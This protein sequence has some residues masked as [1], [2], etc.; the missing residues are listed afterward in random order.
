M[1]RRRQQSGRGKHSGR[2]AHWASVTN[3]HKI[4]SRTV[5]LSCLGR[6]RLSAR[7]GK[8]DRCRLAT[9]HCSSAS[10]TLQPPLAWTSRNRL[11]TK[12]GVPGIADALS[13][14]NQQGNYLPLT[15]P[16]TARRLRA[17]QIR[18]LRFLT[19]PAMSCPALLRGFGTFACDRSAHLRIHAST[20]ATLADVAVELF[21]P[22]R[23]RHHADAKV[24]GDACVVLAALLAFPCLSCQRLAF[25][26]ATTLAWRIH[27]Q[28]P[29][30]LERA[31][32]DREDGFCSMLRP[33]PQRL[34][35]LRLCR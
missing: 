14:P 27:L 22:R 35:A 30:C 24:L 29:A 6:H 18:R 28:L 4:P 8:G 19:R 20:K 7:R 33:F 12:L 21:E 34:A 1:N 32:P 25:L 26:P 11:S 17:A 23:N 2:S 31:A 13:S 9:T 15:G 3:T 10:R 16:C 5:R